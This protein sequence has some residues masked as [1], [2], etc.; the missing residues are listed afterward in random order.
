MMFAQEWSQVCEEFVLSGIL[1]ELQRCETGY[2]ANVMLA[3]V[4]K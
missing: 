2:L 1:P 4:W 3:E